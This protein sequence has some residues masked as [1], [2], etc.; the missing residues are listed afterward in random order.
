MLVSLSY[1]HNYCIPRSVDLTEDG[2]GT[3]AAGTSMDFAFPPELS[4]ALRRLYHMRR[5]PF[6][7]PGPLQSEDD[8]AALR[9]FFVRFPLEECLAMMAP[10]LWSSGPLE[11]A[12]RTGTPLY[13]S[14]PPDTLSLWENVRHCVFGLLRL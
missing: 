8:R 2:G 9:A 5:G 13:D 4:E 11:M 10:E 12:M 7:S 14:V 3:K 6:L 1:P